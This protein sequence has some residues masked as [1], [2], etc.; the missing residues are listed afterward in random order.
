MTVMPSS[1]SKPKQIGQGGGWGC[2]GEKEK[3][4][5]KKEKVRSKK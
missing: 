4:K 2:M 1:V 3:G 5:R